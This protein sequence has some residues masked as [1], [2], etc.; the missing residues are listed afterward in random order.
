[1]KTS[2]MIRILQGFP[3]DS[4]VCLSIQWSNGKVYADDIDVTL[5]DNGGEV[6]IDGWADNV[7]GNIEFDDKDEDEDM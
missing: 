6:N 2:E 1:M 3:P 7:V 4:R 5:S